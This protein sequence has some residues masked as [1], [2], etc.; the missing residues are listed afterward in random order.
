[1]KKTRTKRFIA[2]LLTLMMAFTICGGVFAEDDEEDSSSTASSTGTITITNAQSGVTYT[3]YKIFDVTIATTSSSSTDEDGNTTTTTENTGY[4]YTIAAD[5]AWLSS[6]LTYANAT[7]DP[8]SETTSSKDTT[9]DTTTEDSDDTTTG[10][11]S[12][13]TSSDSTTDDSTSDN[14]SNWSSGLTLTLSADSS[15][16][17]VTVDE[18]TFSAAKFASYLLSV[19]KSSSESSDESESEDTTEDSTDSSDSSD[20]TS[21]ASTTFTG[22]SG[23]TDKDSEG[24]ETGTYTISN[25]ELGYYLVVGTTTESS[26]DESGDSENDTDDDDSESTSTGTT[27]YQGLAELTTTDTDVEIYDKNAAQTIS[28]EADATAGSVEIGEN[29]SF[30][31][32]GT[33]PSLT[34]YTTYTYTITDSMTD[35]LTFTEKQM[36]AMDIEL[37]ED[38][39]K[40]MT[41]DDR[42]EIQLYVVSSTD[43]LGNTIYSVVNYVETEDESYDSSKTYYT[44]STSGTTTY[45]AASGIESFASGTTY[46]EAVTVGSLTYVAATEAVTDEEGTVTTEATGGGFTLSLDMTLLQDYVGYEIGILYKATANENA[47]ATTET[48][49]ATLTYSTDPDD[50]SSTSTATATATVYTSN[51]IIYKVDSDTVTTTTDG[52]TSYDSAT[53]LSGASFVLIEY[54]SYSDLTSWTEGTTYYTKS[55][56]ANSDGGY[57]YTE[58][59]TTETTSPTSGTDYY[60]QR[61]YQYLGMGYTETTDTEYVSG[62]TYY[63]ASTDE[64]GNTTYTKFTGTSFDDGT[65][66][67]EYS[68]TG[69]VS[70]TEDIDEATVLTTG[71]DGTVTIMGLDDLT[72]YL[73]EIEAPD[74]YNLLTSTV[75]VK[76][77]AGDNTYSYSVY[78]ENSSG[79]I[80]PAT[81]GMGRTIVYVIGILIIICACAALIVRRR[82]SCKK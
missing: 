67:Y 24:N 8:T 22:T 54:K 5:S 21:S 42:D 25:L 30:Y 9:E 72:Y 6:V 73:L 19:L 38:T 40:N 2:L 4:A 14:S 16:Y 46:Y 36:A 55:S 10:D 37:Y 29:I 48:N 33:V 31:I 69:D 65:T 64:D 78:V 68:A 82:I 63:T 17:V 7:S 35:G 43:E 58:V 77:A 3:A 57:T 45:T 76:V 80:L 74:G 79:S 70:W 15:C 11:S 28:K 75:T 50:S 44:K 32:Y 1:M 62:T 39:S 49:T 13:G 60:V 53:K 23:S 47:D 20:T 41:D 27:V 61:Y 18:D 66:Y 56:E 26:D 71:D 81:G 34:G 59:N 52:S 12:D 51:I